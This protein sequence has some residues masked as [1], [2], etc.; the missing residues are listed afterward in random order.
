MMSKSKG[1]RRWKR[2]KKE[3]NNEEKTQSFTKKIY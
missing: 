1:I 2:K 3:V